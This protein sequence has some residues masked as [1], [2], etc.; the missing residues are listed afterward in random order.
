M[1]K[2]T[3]EHITEPFRKNPKQASMVIAINKVIT[4]A[5]YIAYPILLIYLFL[6]EGRGGLITSYIEQGL[7]ARAFL[8]PFIS[9]ILVTILRNVV[10]EKRPYEVF[11]MKPII[12]K[13]TKG[14][15]F[16][17]RHAFSI[18]VIGITFLATLD[19]LVP[20]IV[21]L[22]MGVMLSVVRVMGGVHYPR[23]VIAG[24]LLGIL[25]GLIGF[26]LL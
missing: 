16:P 15:S 8:V 7:F 22:V 25:A 9:F 17:S 10:N 18:F 23:D 24:A 4:Y 14:K 3:Y 13:T 12:P 5:I 26:Y 21:I 1:K 6:T 2:K 19:T 11:E 20:G